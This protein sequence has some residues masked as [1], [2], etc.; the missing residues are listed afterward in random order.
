M[1]TKT[2]EH[3]TILKFL[4]NPKQIL[5][6]LPK[7]ETIDYVWQQKSVQGIAVAEKYRPIYGKQVKQNRGIV[8]QNSSKRIESIDVRAK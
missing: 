8:S 3:K 6:N 4:N 2:G 7:T 1:F 5:V